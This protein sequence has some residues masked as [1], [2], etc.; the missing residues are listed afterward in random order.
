[1]LCSEGYIKLKY[2]PGFLSLQASG[3]LNKNE[4]P[5]KVA[6]IKVIKDALARNNNNRNA[7]AKDLGIHKSTLFRRINKLGL[8]L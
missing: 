8:K 3:I 4:N 7:A 2:L 5:V 6:Q 1:V